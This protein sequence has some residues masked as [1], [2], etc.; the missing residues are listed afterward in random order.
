MNSLVHSQPRRAIILSAGQG[1]RLLP[2]TADRPKCLIE[3]QGRAV[4]EH[5]I[6]HLIAAGFEHISVVI[7]YSAAQVEQRLSQRYKDAPAVIE[8]VFNPFFELADNLASCWMARTAMMNGDFLILN[9]DTLFELPVLE[10]LMAS[11][12]GPITLAI[13]R[14]NAY[15]ADDMKVILEGERLVRVGKKLDLQVVNGESIGMMVFRGE[16][17][18]LFH[19]ALE[20]IMR[21]PEALTR[22]YL[23]V[24]DELAATGQVFTQS[25]EGLAWAELDFPHDLEQARR[26]ATL[27]AAVETA[28]D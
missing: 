18:A 10:R 22:W 11:P 3:F 5:Q 20:R 17:S 8:P 4:I 13:D 6:D 26:L 12:S 16:G 19:N 25:I 21:T 15:D 28:H 7:G 1:K 14:K 24:I 2:H 23:S 9:G 27:D